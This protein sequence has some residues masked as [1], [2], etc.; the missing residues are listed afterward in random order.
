MLGFLG[1]ILRE[2]TMTIPEICV[3]ILDGQYPSIELEKMG[4]CLKEF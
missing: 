3:P 4:M 2:I 1:G